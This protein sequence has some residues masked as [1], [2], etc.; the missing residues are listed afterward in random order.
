MKIFEIKYFQIWI[1]IKI[2]ILFIADDAD[3]R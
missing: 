2:Q 1:N 3:R